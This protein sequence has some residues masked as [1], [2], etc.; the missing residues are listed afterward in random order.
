[1]GSGLGLAQVFGFA[2]QSGGGVSIH[3]EPGRGTR[4]K[5]YLPCIHDDSGEACGERP[6]ALPAPGPSSTAR[7]ILLVDD[8]P[9]VREVTAAL[10]NALGYRVLEVGSGSEAL[11]RLEQGVDL[12]LTDYAMPGMN[13]AELASLAQQQQPGLPVIFITGYA[14]LGGLDL[15]DQVVMQKP[16]READIA[17]K[18]RAALEERP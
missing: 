4:V 18:L 16:F 5:V 3:T 7:T 10:L 9:R 2:K 8:D 6:A 12:L 11:Q 1:K 13:G 17:A 14:E 15:P